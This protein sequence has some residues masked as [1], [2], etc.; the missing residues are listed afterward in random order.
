MHREEAE[1][2][3]QAGQTPQGSGHQRRGWGTANWQGERWKHCKQDVGG[4]D[5]L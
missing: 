3:V 5:M 1:R 2:W 4:A